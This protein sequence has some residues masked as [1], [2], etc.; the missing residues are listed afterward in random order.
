[1]FHPPGLSKVYIFAN[2][3]VKPTDPLGTF[4]LG[5]SK[6]F[7]SHGFIKIT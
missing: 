2:C 3:S 4:T 5:V 1:M 7:H 6:A